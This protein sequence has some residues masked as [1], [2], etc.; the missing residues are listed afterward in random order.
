MRVCNYRIIFA[1]DATTIP[2]IYV[3]RRSTTT[4]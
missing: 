1:E 4:Y 3:G 2:A